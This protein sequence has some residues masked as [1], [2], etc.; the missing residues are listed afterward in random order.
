MN[1]TIKPGARSGRV[2]IPAS[3]SYAHRQ[4]ICAALAVNMSGRETVIECDGMSK[5]ILATAECLKRLGAGIDIEDGCIV[6]SA[7]AGAFSGLRRSNQSGASSDAEHASGESYEAVL[8]CNESGEAILPCNESGSTLRFMLPVAAALGARARFEMADGLA[9]RPVDAL[10]NVMTEHGVQVTK[11]RNCISIEGR[12]SAGEYSIPGN[13][14][15]QYISGL[16]MAL[17][18]LDGD[19]SLKVTGTIESADYIKI[20]EDTLRSFGVKLTTQCVAN[21]ADSINSTIGDNSA[22]INSDTVEA[23]VA[24]GRYYII[25]G[26]RIF[27]SKACMSVEQDWSNAA[28]FMCMGALSKEG[29]TLEQMPLNS[30]QGDRAIMQVI[31]DMGAEICKDCSDGTCQIT[32]RRKSLTGITV[33]ASAIPDLVPTIAALASLC[34]GTTRIIN[35]QRLRIKES[36]RL[37][38]TANMLKALG[39]DV[40]ELDDGLII[41]GKKSLAGGTVDACNDHRIAMAAAVA[42]CGCT[43]DVTVLGAEC[44]AK[45]FPAFWERLELLTRCPTAPL[46]RCPTDPLT[47]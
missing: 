1:Y 39:A 25:P 19:S 45:S 8:P 26:N 40:T 38:T 23:D 24:T 27:T 18:L 15:S 29:I 7:G 13:V 33:D 3:K 5:D 10:L 4:L 31:E 16:L 21:T 22:D 12:L 36:D 37:R 46:T 32:V 17:P 14:S 6:V 43:G 2:S 41:E 28:F 20:T 35:A 9:A 44:V 47:H 42:A 30:V 34:E 11:G